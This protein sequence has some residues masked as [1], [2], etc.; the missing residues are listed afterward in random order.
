[1][2]RSGIG[3]QGG[4]DAFRDLLGHPHAGGF[5]EV[6][7]HLANGA[8]MRSNRKAILV[9]NQF[10]Y[11]TKHSVAQTKVRDFCL[12]SESTQTG[13]LCYFGFSISRRM[14]STRSAFSSTVSRTKCSAGVCR[15]F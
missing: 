13:S 5:A 12:V 14:E 10:N 7:D 1:M 3:Q 9:F 6:I 4:I 2:K 8:N 11:L 15:K